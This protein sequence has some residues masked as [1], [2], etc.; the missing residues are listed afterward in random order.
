MWNV[1]RLLLAGATALVASNSLG[2]SVSRQSTTPSS[3]DSASSS[4]SGSVPVAAMP[5]SSA[6]LALATYTG[7]A[8]PDELGMVPVLEYHDVQPTEYRWGR[9]IVN[10]KRDLQFLY[11]NGYVTATT[12]DMLAGF[13]DVPAGKKPVVMTFDDARKSQFVASGVDSSGEA[14]PTPTCAVGLMMAFARTHPGFGHRATF[15]VLPSFFEEDKYDAAKLKYLQAHGFEIGN[16]TWTHLQM[17][18]ASPEEIR[19][20]LARLQAAVDKELGEPGFRTTT[21]AY[22]DGSVPR[23]SA[24]MA[25]AVGGGSAPYHIL[26]MLL[27]GANPALSP[28]DKHF[29]PLRIARIQAIDE[30]WKQWFNRRSAS[31]VGVDKETFHPYVSDGNPATLTFPKKYA[32]RLS[33]SAARKY[34]VVAYALGTVPPTMA[35]ASASSRTAGASASMRVASAAGSNRVPGFS[36]PLPKGGIYKDGK[37]FHKVQPGQDLDSLLDRYLPFTWAYTTHDLRGIVMKANGLKHP[38]VNPGKTIVIPDVLP[39]PLHPTPQGW[40][41][42]E[43]VK[44]IYCTS[45]TAGMDRIFTLARQLKAVGGNAVVFDAKDGPVSFLSKDPLVRKDSQWDHTVTDLPKLVYLLHKMGIHVIARQVL[46]HDPVLAQ[47]RHD[48][49]IHKK[50]DPGQVWLEEGKLDWVDASLP[51]VQEYNLRLAKELAQSGVDEIQFD[52]VRFPAQGDT[53][54]CKFAFDPKVTPKWRVLQNFLER[55]HAE[56]APYHV[57]LGIDTYGIMAWNRKVDRQVTGQEIQKLCK[58]VDVICPMVYP[59]HF[60]GPFEG[61]REPGK[62]PYYMLS[63]SITRTFFDIQPNST[64]IRPWIQAFNFRSPNFSPTYVERELRG[65]RDAHATGWLLWNAGNKYDIGFAGVTMWNRAEASTPPLAVHVK[66]LALPKRI[67]A[68]LPARPH[69]R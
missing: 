12:Q 57:P 6:S 10:F 53:Q 60:Y 21:L 66:G 28:F 44:G 19:S 35:G 7:K 3:R 63:Q 40:P 59:S 14:I 4:S 5:A 8:M 43:P 58:Y 67:A 39:G 47:R 26:A 31:D 29:D 30:E 18:K 9:S 17:G 42:G 22:P 69:S 37:I 34:K 45:T 61:Y 48:L 64:I 32:S 68:R 46:F 55:A 2:C 52:Y 11:D 15:Y 20:Q 25:A 54:D 36:E 38:W 16:H 27:V 23:T 51:E 56:L 13:P 62:H 65:A 24:Q 41:I 33:P 50:D 1:R 49:D